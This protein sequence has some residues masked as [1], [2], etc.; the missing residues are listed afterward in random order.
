MRTRINQAA[1]FLGL[2]FLLSGCASGMRVYVNPEADMTFYE[3]IAIVPFSNLTTERFA[4][5]RVGRAFTT[6]LLISDHFKIIEE[7]EFNAALDRIGGEANVEGLYDIAKLKTAAT[8]L[9]ATGLLRGSVT[10]YQMQRVGSSES[11]VITFDVEMLD[12]ATGNVVWRA[13]LTRRGKGTVPL[14]GGD[15]T[16]TFGRLV[17]S[18]CRD[19][20]H[21]LESEAF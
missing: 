12:V 6:E 1:G 16:R 20:V 7:G 17:Q 13:S 10:E 8:E 19:M 15:G 18:A 3:K 2:L 14:L 21:K 11:P 9:E 5:H 4:A